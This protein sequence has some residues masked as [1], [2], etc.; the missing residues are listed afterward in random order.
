MCL[1]ILKSKCP[2]F[3]KKRQDNLDRKDKEASELL[4]TASKIQDARDKRKAEND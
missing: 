1:S 4:E 3:E 2:S